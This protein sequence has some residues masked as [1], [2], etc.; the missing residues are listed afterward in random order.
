[1]LN[2]LK[3]PFRKA[4]FSVSVAGSNILTDLSIPLAAKR[5]PAGVIFAVRNVV[6]WELLRAIG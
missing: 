4:V 3:F 5:S 2:D 6:F 1:M